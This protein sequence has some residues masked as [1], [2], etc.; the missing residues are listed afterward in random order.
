M[1]LFTFFCFANCQILSVIIEHCI[2][3]VSDF[4]TLRAVKRDEPFS[5]QVSCI[6]FVISI[7]TESF[8]QTS[9]MSGLNFSM[10]TTLRISSNDGSGATYSLKCNIFCQYLIVVISNSC[11]VQ[12]SNRGVD[13]I[14]NPGAC[15]CAGL[16]RV[17]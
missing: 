16:N 3:V 15:V 14:L 12:P 4:L 13:N 5:V 11:F 2:I 17:S 8:S 6:N 9:G 7:K 1:K 10:H